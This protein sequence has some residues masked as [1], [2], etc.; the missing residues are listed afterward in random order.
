MGKSATKFAKNIPQ[1]T[2]CQDINLD[3]MECPNSSC[4]SDTVSDNSFWDLKECTYLNFW[5]P[6]YN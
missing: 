6:E 1:K 4:D 3:E 5:D 2:N